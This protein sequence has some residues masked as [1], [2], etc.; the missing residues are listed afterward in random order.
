[1]TNRPG[2]KPSLALLMRAL[3]VTVPV[4]GS[5]VFSMNA[6]VPDCRLVSS[7]IAS[8]R[9]GPLAIAARRSGRITC[10]IAKVT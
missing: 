3:A 6:I 5:T 10:G 1:M 7:T 9:T 2:H 8:T 4:L